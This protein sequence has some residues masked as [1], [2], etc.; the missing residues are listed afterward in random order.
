[1]LNLSRLESHLS[2]FRWLRWLALVQI[3]FF[4][5]SSHY[6]S[7]V[8][9]RLMLVLLLVSVN[10]LWSHFTFRQVGHQHALLTGPIEGLAI[11]YAVY[12]TGGV[13]S[14][15]YLALFIGLPVAARGIAPHGALKL[16]AVIAPLYAMVARFGDPVHT[17][18]DLLVLGF[19]LSMLLMM[20]LYLDALVAK[21]AEARREA[22][23]L[24]SEVSQAHRQLQDSARRLEQTNRQLDHKV[25]DL[26]LLQETSL[27]LSS[28]LE[29]NKIIR[30]LVDSA[31]RITA[32]E[33][34]YVSICD[35]QRTY[36]TVVF[37]EGL[38]N[39]QLGERLPLDR[40]LV[41]WAAVNRQGVLVPDRRLDPRV[42][43]SYHDS[44]INSLMVVPLVAND[45]TAGV[46]TLGSVGYAHFTEDHLRLFQILGVQ[47]GLAIEN[48]HLYEQTRQSALTDGLTGLYNYR[49]FRSRF[50]DEIR[51][52]DRSQ[53][54]VGLL[55][56]DVDG[57]KRI[58]DTHGHPQGDSVLH[59]LAQILK[60]SLRA[61]D[62]VCRTGGEEFSI[63]LPDTGRSGA[64][65][66]GCMLVEKVGNHLFQGD[67][68]AQGGR[69]TISVGL[70]VYPDE[71]EDDLI[72]LA[73]HRM[74]RAKTAG[75]NRLNTE[76][77]VL[78]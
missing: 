39:T 17:T 33:N 77:I 15:F 70:S 58:N 43:P 57:F 75:G 45:Q 40:G 35:P 14:E 56:I 67:F 68:G 7:S 27:A 28:S 26:V 59:E 76:P 50:E 24:L 6:D 4:V 55:M 30:L 8:R 44:P 73:D 41:G 19:R 25:R 34:C 38:V 42:H 12:V 16:L 46:L 31:R 54:R 66:V 18:T 69:V 20:G 36:R 60:N 65:H 9:L 78:Q 53:S 21:G 72:R 71:R 23:D 62:I 32:F 11:L 2:Q 22:Q 37:A 47:A 49:Y 29:L 10:I 64:E 52:A 3:S 51:R 48:A 74:Y 63:I 1:M 13:Q 5:L 61:V